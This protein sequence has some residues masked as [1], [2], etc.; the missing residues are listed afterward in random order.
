MLRPCSVFVIETP[1][2]EFVDSYMKLS[3]WFTNL[4]AL[5]GTKYESICKIVKLRESITKLLPRICGSS[6]FTNR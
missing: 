5:V 2:Y 6:F 3:G 4:R 1:V